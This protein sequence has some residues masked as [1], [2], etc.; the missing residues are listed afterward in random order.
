MAHILCRLDKFEEVH[1][2]EVASVVDLN[3]DTPSVRNWDA[4]DCKEESNP[5]EEA[6][7][8]FKFCAVGVEVG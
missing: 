4:M 1:L 3:G 6:P 5:I 8:G 2:P 7:D